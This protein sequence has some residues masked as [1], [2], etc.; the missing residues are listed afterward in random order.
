MQIDWNLEEVLGTQGGI[1][2]VSK[3]TAKISY[4]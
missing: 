2:G 3:V 4:S 1:A